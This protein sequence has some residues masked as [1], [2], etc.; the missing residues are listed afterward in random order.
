[1]DY[2]TEKQ[3]LISIAR[4]SIN[5][6][7]PFLADIESAPELRLIQWGEEGI[8]KILEVY[9]E[10]TYSDDEPIEPVAVHSLTEAGED[11]YTDL[12]E[13]SNNEIRAILGAVGIDTGKVDL[14][15]WENTIR[16]LVIA[17]GEEEF[18]EGTFRFWLGDLN[19]VCDIAGHTDVL[20]V[21]ATSDWVNA[22]VNTPDDDST[23]F[24]NLG[25]LPYR[26]VKEI[27]NQVKAPIV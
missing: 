27:L 24:V 1:M 3:M 11:D 8:E 21:L 9:I 16:D 17:K 7:G 10:D 15:E 18:T 12:A 2:N 23:I 6:N 13:F 14:L 20:S 4:E 26:V 19:G 25:E 22:Q 5:A